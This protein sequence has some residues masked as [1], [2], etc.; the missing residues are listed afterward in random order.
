MVDYANETYGCKEINF[1]CM[2]I[3]KKME[4]SIENNE[5][6]KVVYVKYYS[7]GQT[8]FMIC[9]RIDTYNGL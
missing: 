7:N 5:E 2:D 1:H 9:Q 4:D 8:S 6:Q 3:E